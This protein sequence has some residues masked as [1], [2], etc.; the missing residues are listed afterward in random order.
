MTGATRRPI[1]VPPGSPPPPPPPSR[2]AGG[3]PPA[4]RP[5]KGLIGAAIGLVFVI[6]VLV[7]AAISGRGGFV[8]IGDTQVAVL[9]HF[10]SGEV[11]LVTTPGYRL[12]PPFLS[13]AYIFDKSPN[14]FVM[15]GD[16]DRNYDHV[17]RL[18]VRAKDG[19]NFW[20]ET[21]EIQYQLIASMAPEVLADSGPGDSFKV[22]WVRAFARSVLRDEFGRYSTEEVADP[23]SYT[24]AT[25][26]ATERLNDLLRPHGVQIVQII[27]PKP[28]FEDLYENAIEDRKVANQEVERL[29][30]RGEQLKRERER[31]LADIERD[32][33]T[34]YE[35]LLGTLEAERINAEKDR[36][37]LEKSADAFKV[38]ALADGQAALQKMREEARGLEEQ[39]RKEAEGMRARV[40]ALAAGGAVLVR[41]ALAE[42]LAQI[43][44]EVV[45][46]Q[47]DPAPVR[48]EH[49]GATS[50]GRTP[51]A[52][53]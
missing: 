11:E 38:K 46:F 15:E 24:Q 25:M 49:L 22:H 20:F 13:Q 31:R 21:L 40:E 6:I 4:W 17:S 3:G 14:K 30:A 48:I 1:I 28:K 12:F 52:N 5:P 41:E 27:T 8:E 34:E 32:M 42:K 18:T 2:P 39:A 53:R 23:T 43:R 26:R 35:Q 50:S 10:S 51:G 44:F 36:V 29:R 7:A 19:S 45:P 9:V 33:A 16:R 37:R 47:R